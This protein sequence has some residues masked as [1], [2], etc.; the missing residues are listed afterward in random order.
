MTAYIISGTQYYSALSPAPTA[1]VDTI[2]Q[3]NDSIYIVDVS[4]VPILVH[5]CDSRFQTARFENASTTTPIFP[6]YSSVTSSFI[7]GG[8][9]FEFEGDFIDLFT[10]DGVTAGL[11][12]TLPTDAAGDKYVSASHLIIDGEIWARSPNLTDMYGDGDPR[13]MHYTYDSGTGVITFGDGTNGAIPDGLVQIYNIELQGNN[14]QINHAN[15]ITTVNKALWC[16]VDLRIGGVFNCT[17]FAIY[18][19]SQEFRASTTDDSYLVNFGYSGDASNNTRIRVP[20]GVHDNVRLT[21]ANAVTTEVFKDEG[22]ATIGE[23]RCDILAEKLGTFP[24]VR[25]DNN[26][27]TIQ[28]LRSYSGG[29]GIYASY[30][31]FNGGTIEELRWST[32]Y[33][34]TDTMPY[35][36]VKSAGSGQNQYI[37]SVIRDG[38]EA[39]SSEMEWP[40]YG[41][42]G[43]LHVSNMELPADA[44]VDELIHIEAAASGS[45]TNITLLGTSNSGTRDL[46]V[47]Q[48]GTYTFNNVK[49]PNDVSFGNQ[50]S[51]DCA[52][53][54]VSIIGQTF[55]PNGGLRSATI[56]KNATYDEGEIVFQPY[57]KSS[58]PATT[59]LS[60]VGSSVVNI[61]NSFYM[62]DTITEVQ[63]TSDWIA[64]VEAIN[65]LTIVGFN[66]GNFDIEFRLAVEGD[67]FSGSF[68]ALTLGNFQ[69]AF[70]ALV[71]PTTSTRWRCQYNVI[72]TAGVMSSSYLRGIYVGC[73]LD[74]TYVWTDSPEMTVTLTG[75][76]AGWTI[77][78]ADAA[79]NK[80][81]YSTA[82]WDTEIIE[83]SGLD[84]GETY[85]YAVDTQGKTADIG[86]FT[87]VSGGSL[88]IPVVLGPLTR[89]AGQDMYTGT[90]DANISIDFDFVTPQAS[91]VIADNSVASL[92]T[93]FDMFEDA[94]ITEDGMKW[95]AQQGSIVVFDSIAASGSVL[96]LGD[97]CRL[98]NSVANATALGASVDG[99]VTS[100]QG[101]VLDTDNGK[102]IYSSA[103]VADSIL[104]RNLAGGSDGG[105]TV[106]DA[107]RGSRNK[108]A[109]VN[110]SMTVYQEDDA[111]V[112]WTA[113]LD[114]A[115]RGAINTVDPT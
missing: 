22:V 14:V 6:R 39:W 115:T 16:D 53:N 82:T 103:G 42:V 67:A 10:A 69:T 57:Y 55:A 45:A 91:I 104:N 46:N 79:G 74:P 72:R 20:R 87:V 15:T 12:H 97:D 19:N 89:L 11:T 35:S 84:D 49:V 41:Q 96:G 36:I 30:N 88:I 77:Y 7:N 109:I 31:G 81:F 63:V 94:L 32:G 99:Y 21:T 75:L 106:R 65:S 83:V 110:N 71:L 66:T 3:S 33:L 47:F 18:N 113:D 112:A 98:K 4:T 85:S 34:R 107:L 9:N 90:T 93:C 102:V 50:P 26:A 86:T 17:D 51:S 28:V 43:E 80:K 59:L 25:F 1:D 101:T 111:T 54:F 29:S 62:V 2:D 8:G 70:A 73:D 108:V 38:T 37:N 61:T 100:T 13:G 24:R 114:I 23:I 105:R 68:S 64:A 48:D 92:Q 52:Y 5:Y 27:S 58:D 76:T 56:Y 78:L 60:G 40:I 44:S 95:H